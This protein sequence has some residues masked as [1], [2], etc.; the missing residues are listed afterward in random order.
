MN[1]PLRF[2]V[3]APPPA[4][5]GFETYQ[6]T[7]EFNHEVAQRQAHRAYCDW[8]DAVAAQHRRE[9]EQMQGDWNLF[10]WFVRR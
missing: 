8:Y 3:P 10:G 9:L 4:Q 1:E 5:A 7:W 6:L 2:I